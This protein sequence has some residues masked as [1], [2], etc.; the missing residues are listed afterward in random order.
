MSGFGNLWRSRTRKHVRTMYSIPTNT[1]PGQVRWPRLRE[2]E[3]IGWEMERLLAR[4]RSHARRA[5]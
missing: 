5:L 3:R 4:Q 2:T 1:G